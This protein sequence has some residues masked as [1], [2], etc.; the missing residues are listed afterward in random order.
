[1]LFMWFQHNFEILGVGVVTMDRSFINVFPAVHS[2][3]EFYRNILSR[4][5][6]I[7]AEYWQNYEENIVV[8]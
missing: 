3:H 4:Q 8:K 6:L 1:M 7:S 2:M 5:P